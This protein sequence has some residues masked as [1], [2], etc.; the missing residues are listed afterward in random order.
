MRGIII[1]DKNKERI[2]KIVKYA[3][4]NEKDI[5]LGIRENQIHLYVKGGS[6]FL[7]FCTNGDYAYINSKYIYAKN[8]K[9]LID[10]LKVENR[11]SNTETKIKID[12]ILDNNMLDMLKQKV[13]GYEK[14]TPEK[15]FKQMLIQEINTNSDYY[16]YDIEYR[17]NSKNKE[18]NKKYI[19]AIH[20]KNSQPDLMLISKPVNNKIEILFC[21]VKY[22]NK[23]FNGGPLGSGIVGHVGK[24]VKFINLANKYDEI[25]EDL[26]T[27][28]KNIMGFYADKNQGLIKN[29]NFADIKYD[30]IE[31]KPGKDAI[32]FCF[33]LGGCDDKIE[34]LFKNRL[35]LEEKDIKYN[36]KKLLNRKENEKIENE[37][38][39]YYPKYDD[40][41]DFKYMRYDSNGRIKFD[42]KNDGK[43]ISKTDFRR[44]NVYI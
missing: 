11:K 23:S 6:R 17:F 16:A 36:V 31:L 44:D 8:G 1:T 37:D 7:R 35:G 33:I 26:L 22:G 34:S 19:D 5:F 25:K 24:F 41:V 30:D 4:A 13:E 28:V 20:G 10:D 14:N 12:Y 32:Q 42:L 27:E 3:K 21:E 40:M 38:V 2:Q 18:L 15:E 29:K 9:L 43:K 39:M